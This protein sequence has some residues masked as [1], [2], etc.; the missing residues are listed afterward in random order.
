[1]AAEEQLITPSAVSQRIKNLEDQLQFK[2][3]N[4]RNNSIILTT[5]GNA[6]VANVRE[7]LDKILSAGLEAKAHDRSTVLK[8]STLP[9]F[10]VRWLLPRLSSF[11]EQA[12][13]IRLNLANSYA[14]VNFE[15]EDFDAAIRYGNGE[16]GN[17][18]S[19]LLFSETLT[20]VCTP[21]LLDQKIPDWRQ[22]I[23][24]KDISKLTLLHSDT[25]HL[26]WHY[27]FE[28]QGIGDILSEADEAY[29]S[30][31]LYSYEAATSGLGIAIANQ[32]YMTADIET[33]K[34]VAPFKSKLSSGCGWYFVYPK[35]NAKLEKIQQFDQWIH[36]QALQAEEALKTLF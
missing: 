21:E 2:I 35:Q 3:F 10:S 20:P 26:N 27:W 28:M 31:C 8:L 22:S 11:K 17:L 19:R 25:C 5:E 13:A 14:R 18:K 4:R 30:S 12:P 36:K 24:P 6:F 16:F 7:A 23:Q 9:T 33:G 15:R 32:A 29:F 34:L 1:M